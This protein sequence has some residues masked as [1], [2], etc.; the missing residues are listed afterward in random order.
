MS[1]KKSIIKTEEQE[2]K[3]QD[4]KD[5]EWVEGKN[6]IPKGQAIEIHYAK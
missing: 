4:K 2:K 5:Q 1:N 3:E 6:P